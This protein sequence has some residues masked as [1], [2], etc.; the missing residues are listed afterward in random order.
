MEVRVFSLQSRLPRGSGHGGDLP[1]LG[2]FRGMAVSRQSCGSE[3]AQ[4]EVVGVGVG[5]GG[6]QG[7]ERLLAVPRGRDFVTCSDAHPG[8]GSTLRGR[9]ARRAATSK[10]GGADGSGG[11]TDAVLAQWN[12]APF[13]KQQGSAARDEGGTHFHFALPSSRR[14]RERVQKQVH[15]AQ[16]RRRRGSSQL[17]LTTSKELETVACVVP[18]TLPHRL[19]R[20][21]PVETREHAFPSVCDGRRG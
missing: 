10:A 1:A 8:A 2:R 7:K 21:L 15:L 17:T 9:A 5:V 12:G 4:A 13:R 16:G 6:R 19:R 3:Q 14:G 20:A 18:P 11:L